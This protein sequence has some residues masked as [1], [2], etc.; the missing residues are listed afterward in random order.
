MN[1]RFGAFEVL[2]VYYGLLIG[3]RPVI[4]WNV[5]VVLINLGTLGSVR[6]LPAPGKGSST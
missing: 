1:P 3:S 6:L 5:I 2:W 4:L